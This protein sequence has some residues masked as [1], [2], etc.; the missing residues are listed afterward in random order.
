MIEFSGILDTPLQGSELAKLCS[1][2]G[3]NREAKGPNLLF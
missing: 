3:L 1:A 2:W